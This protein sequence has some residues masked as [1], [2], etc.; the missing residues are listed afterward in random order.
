MADL[1]AST[2]KLQLDEVTG[3]M[4]SKNELKKR[5]AKRAKKAATEAARAEREARPSAPTPTPTPPN[6]AV[7]PADEDA[8]FKQGFLAEVYSIRPD[9]DIVTRFPPEP[10]GYLHIGH[11]KAIAVNFGFAKFHGGKTVLRFDDTNPD[12]EEEQYFT[13]IREN[14]RWLGYKPHAVT[15]TSDNFGRLYELA[16]TLIALNRAYVC[17]CSKIEAQK[18]RGGKDGKEGPRY[19][20][21]HADQTPEDN[22]AKF[23]DMRDG[24]YAHGAAFLRM[25][26]DIDS[27]NPQMWDLAAYRIP[28][29]QTPHFRTGTEWNMYPTYDFAHCLCDSFE[30]VT[31][32]LCTTEFILSRESYEWLNRTLGVHEPMQRE[33]GR[34]N[35]SHTIMSKRKLKELV[36]SGHVSGWDDPRLYTINALRRRGIP[37][38]AI[39]SFINELG[40]TTTKTTI[41][42]ARFEQSVR[43]Y[44]ETKV[45]RLML[46]LSPVRVYIDNLDDLEGT[47]LDIPFSSKDPSMGSRKL[48]LTKTIYIDASDFRTE[49]SP[50]YFRLAPGKTVGLLH[51]PF[52][53][54][55]ESYTEDET[56]GE[57][58][59]I[60]ASLVRGEGS[61]PKTYIQWVPGHHWVNE[62]S[63][64]VDNHLRINVRTYSPLFKSEDPT[65]AEGGFMNDL[66]PNSRRE[67]RAMV[68]MAGFE[69]VKRRALEVKPAA[70]DDD[71]RPLIGPECVRFQ[72]MRAG[73]FAMDPDSKDGRIVLNQI[74]SLKEDSAK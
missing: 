40:V 56:I 7:S 31:H 34:L 59:D 61:K 8:M 74:V 16:E 26:M 51:V 25:K 22:L 33:Y 60:H 10:N 58:T 63:R 68:E 66:A 55:A 71:D 17:H 21:E 65:A 36:D 45:P 32:S 72:G 1:A 2:A 47:E 39:L 11:A 46:L 62:E 29:K 19:R 48:R 53:I 41:Q 64:M 5:T 43:R 52:P 70:D 44:L 30:G 49:D 23:R 9:K 54:R 3:E 14:I 4:V 6:P 18:Q 13:A 28:E 73:Y 50:G 15:Y 42:A 38:G 57:V 69:E 24:K 12:K 20:C 35:V 67:H 27:G 37:P